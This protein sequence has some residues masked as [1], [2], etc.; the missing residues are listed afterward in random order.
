MPRLS[1]TLEL[2]EKHR[3]GKKSRCKSNG[4]TEVWA[5]VIIVMWESDIMISLKH[6]FN[7]S[8]NMGSKV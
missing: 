4:T 1:L 3:E 7:N 6:G 8:E 2:K 5:S